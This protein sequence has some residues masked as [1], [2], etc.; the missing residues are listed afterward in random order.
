MKEA[1][2]QKAA[3]AGN[4]DLDAYVASVRAYLARPDS[5]KDDGVLM[6]NLKSKGNNQWQDANG[7]KEP[8]ASSATAKELAKKH[9]TKRS[10]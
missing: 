2:I 7:V 9:C 4:N 8:R 3:H 5:R 6:Q 10:S 1:N